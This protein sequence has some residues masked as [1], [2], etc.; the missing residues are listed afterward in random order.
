MEITFTRSGE[1]TYSTLVMRDDG[2]LVEVP[3]SDRSSSLPHDIAHYIVERELGLSRGFWG[4]VAAGAMFGGMRVVSGRRRPHASER[5]RAVIKEAGPR[6][7]EAEIYVLVMQRAAQDGLRN[8]WPSV[9]ARLDEAWRPFRE[10]RLRVGA[11][12]ATRVFD[13]LC[14][15][16]ERWRTLS[17]GESLTF[18]WE[19]Q[20]VRMLKRTPDK[21]AFRPSRRMRAG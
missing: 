12:D 20:P 16:E 15:A 7:T 10:P 1:R 18:E 2:V 11:V 4:C 21:R 3:A 17:F 13:A 6:L 14:R 9:R 8:D 19:A 5:S